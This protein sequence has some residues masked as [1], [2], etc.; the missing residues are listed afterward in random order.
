MSA[1][2]TPPLLPARIEIHDIK[3][4]DTRKF[5]ELKNTLSLFHST[6]E[7]CL[8]D[9]ANE[10]EIIADQ[11][12]A[13]PAEDK[14]QEKDFK[15][16]MAVVGALSNG[17]GDILLVHNKEKIGTNCTAR[18]VA[19]FSAR[20]GIC[21][22]AEIYKLAQKKNGLFSNAPAVAET[23]QEACEKTAE[24]IAGT[25]KITISGGIDK[26]LGS[27]FTDAFLFKRNNFP[28][29]GNLPKPDYQPLL[30]KI[31]LAA[32]ELKGKIETKKRQ[33]IVPHIYK[34]VCGI[35]SG[36]IIPDPSGVEKNTLMIGDFFNREIAKLGEPVSDLFL[37]DGL[38][39]E[40]DWAGAYREQ[41]SS[42]GGI[43]ASMK[44]YMELLAYYN[45]TNEINR[46]GLV[47]AET[48]NQLSGDNQEIQLLPSFYLEKAVELMPVLSEAIS[49]KNKSDVPHS[50]RT[51]L[52]RLQQV[53]NSLCRSDECYPHIAGEDMKELYDIWRNRG[54]YTEII[55]MFDDIGL[56]DALNEIF[57]LVRTQHKDSDLSSLAVRF[58]VLL[59]QDRD[60][61]QPQAS[62]E[63]STLA[64][65]EKIVDE[66]K[67]PNKAGRRQKP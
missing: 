33:G 14:A 29:G 3:P 22:I 58:N 52:T 49:E 8:Q 20:L 56:T 61:A 13:Y 17:L 43:K 32:R 48:V 35:A 15:D 45:K 37:I 28:P 57:P 6:C 67:H 25:A 10:G 62:I 59:C 18:G 63:A 36:E 2:K 38:L 42:F 24:E 16:Q 30:R 53:A 19:D 7:G 54:G 40:A 26:I 46:Q 41:K 4:E 27:E 9:L 21:K 64:Q 47:A 1:P 11:T 39:N 51:K 12:G 55:K 31:I 5:R 34:R 60:T 50:Y 44:H 23:L 65:L 66:I